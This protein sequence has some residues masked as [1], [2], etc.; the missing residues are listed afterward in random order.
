MKIH[1]I[2]LITILLAAFSSIVFANEPLS[3]SSQACS[4][5]EVQFIKHLQKAS[6]KDLVNLVKLL[7]SSASMSHK[8]ELRFAYLQ[9]QNILKVRLLSQS[10][11]FSEFYGSL[12]ESL[13]KVDARLTGSFLKPGQSTAIPSKPSESKSPSAPPQEVSDAFVEANRLDWQSFIAEAWGNMLEAIELAK[14]SSAKFREAFA[15]WPYPPDDPNDPDVNYNQGIWNSQR[16]TLE[17]VE[18]EDIAMRYF[19]L[20]DYETAIERIDLV[21][22]EFVSNYVSS[23]YTEGSYKVDWLAAVR[24][25][26][27]FILIEKAMAQL[28]VPPPDPPPTIQDAAIEAALRELEAFKKDFP[29]EKVMLGMAIFQQARLLEAIGQTV[30]LDS[31]YDV[32]NKAEDALLQPTSK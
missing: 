9:L 2:L 10:S 5:F 14:Q 6:D 22:S 31:S 1:S 3:E 11:Q 23:P 30:Y 13:S 18:Y 25:S 7:D 24:F 28:P 17:G 20:K 29:D 32:D 16:M 21:I 15:I 19:S 12:K 4:T 26:R 27:A 8:P